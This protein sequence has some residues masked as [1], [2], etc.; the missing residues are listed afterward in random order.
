MGSR[1]GKYSILINRRPKNLQDVSRDRVTTP[2]KCEVDTSVTYKCWN[3]RGLLGG[4]IEVFIAYVM[5]RLQ[6][7]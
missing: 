7:L 2:I 3:S 5:C 4:Y 1:M 6:N